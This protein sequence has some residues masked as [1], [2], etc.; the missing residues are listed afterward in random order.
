MTQ[1]MVPK[2]DVINGDL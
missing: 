1:Y 2:S